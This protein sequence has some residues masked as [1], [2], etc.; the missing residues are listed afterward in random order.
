M[1]SIIS[2]VVAAVSVLMV[3]YCVPYV[4]YRLLCPDAI[5][6]YVGGHVL[7]PSFVTSAWPRGNPDFTIDAHSRSLGSAYLGDSFV[8]PS[9]I[10]R[11]ASWTGLDI[12]TPLNDLY[13]PMAR[14]DHLLTGRYARVRNDAGTALFTTRKPG[15]S[16]IPLAR[17]VPAEDITIDDDAISETGFGFI[18]P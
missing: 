14:L 2:R 1:K 15:P 13:Y 18:L 16:P 8:S 3:F 7:R 5:L 11:A 4:A 10:T 9:F 6:Q 12:A 17:N